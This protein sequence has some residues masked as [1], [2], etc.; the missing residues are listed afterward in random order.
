MS[1][2]KFGRVTNSKKKCCVLVKNGIF[3][4]NFY[5]YYYYYLFWL[6][7]FSLDSGKVHNMHEYNLRYKDLTVIL[8]D[9]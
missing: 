6:K 2:L 5:Y 7:L 1:K 9:F 4:P 3:H 8:I